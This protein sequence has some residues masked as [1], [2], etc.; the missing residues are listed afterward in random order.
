MTQGFERG[1][2][3]LW[4]EGGPASQKQLRPPNQLFSHLCMGVGVAWESLSPGHCW[5]PVVLSF[6]SMGSR[7]WLK[8]EDNAFAFIVLWHP[9]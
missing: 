1:K 2:A 4:K 7:E 9:F 6:S 5:H 3:V 8:V